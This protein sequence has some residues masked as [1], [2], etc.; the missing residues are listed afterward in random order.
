MWLMRACFEDPR[1]NV[2]EL[3]RQ[4]LHNI[5]RLRADV[6]V[7]ACEEVDVSKGYSGGGGG[8]GNGNGGKNG[9]LQMRE[10]EGIIWLDLWLPL[11]LRVRASQPLI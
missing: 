1:R 11:I 7:E 4:R 5:N 3:N 10:K 9:G 8:N 6:G 2:A